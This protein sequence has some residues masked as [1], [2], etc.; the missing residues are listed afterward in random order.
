MS[1]PCQDGRGNPEHLFGV[2]WSGAP[3]VYVRTGS[4]PR[5]AY[6]QA[7]SWPVGG[8]YRFW[9]FSMVRERNARLRRAQHLCCWGPQRAKLPTRSGGIPVRPPLPLS[10]GY[11]RLPEESGTPRRGACPGRR[12]TSAADVQR[13]FSA[14]GQKHCSRRGAS[15]CEGRRYG[16]GGM[17][18]LACHAVDE[19]RK[20]SGV[21]RQST[22]WLKA[23]GTEA[24]LFY[25]SW[26]DG[27]MRVIPG[28]PDQARR[29]KDHSPAIDR[30]GTRA[31]NKRSPVRDE[32]TLL[33]GLG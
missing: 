16:L 24:S 28:A 30:W 2:T 15:L 32:R 14:L 18:L 17:L 12:G 3:V 10:A 29:A 9:A 11:C 8:V 7:R 13:R 19:K 5:T 26:P 23:G 25:T 31:A 33:W 4:I 20:I 22:R 27:M 21:R 1:K 6:M